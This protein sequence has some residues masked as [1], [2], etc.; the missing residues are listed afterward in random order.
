MDK[1]LLE[2][3][4]EKTKL[5]KVLKTVNAELRTAP[6]GKVR[7]SKAGKTKQF[8]YYSDK[9][10]TKNGK[11]MKSLEREKAIRL[12]NKEYNYKIK[13]VCEYR[14]KKISEITKLL[15]K[16]NPENIYSQ[17]SDAKREFVTPIFVDDETYIKEWQEVEY[18]GKGFAEGVPEIYSE[19][20]ERVRSKSEK[21]I[22]DR[23][24]KTGIPYRYEYPTIVG[25]SKFHP[26]FTI[27]DIKNRKEILLEH[28]GM[29]DNAEYVSN[30][31]WKIAEYERNG[32]VLGKDLILT[33]ETSREP[34][35]GRMLE[36]A[37]RNYHLI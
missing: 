9:D 8:Y 2:M 17:I 30:A 10:K 21:I 36:R 18:T 5:E 34:F 20:G 35:D 31:L 28:L 22:A 11:Y 27:L 4:K 3:E 13:E 7:V 32:I 24:Y 19:R 37:L 12:I 23:L 25:I 14:L 26:D 15:K 1:L 29:M 33:Y 16:S 6:S